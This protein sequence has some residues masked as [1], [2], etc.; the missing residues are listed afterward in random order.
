MSSGQPKQLGHWFYNIVIKILDREEGLIMAHTLRTVSPSQQGG[1]V[2][3][4]MVRWQRERE[5]KMEPGQD[6]APRIH[7]LLTYFLQPDPMSSFL[8]LPAMTL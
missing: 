3:T 5:C 7:S 4:V 8:Y 6:K 1:A 2:Y